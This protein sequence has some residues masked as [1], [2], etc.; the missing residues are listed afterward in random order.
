MSNP[1]FPVSNSMPQDISIEVDSRYQNNLIE[2]EPEKGETLDR[3][4]Y[5]SVPMHFSG[6]RMHLSTT[7]QRDTLDTFFKTT[8]RYGSIIFDWKHPMTQA[9]AECKMKNL[10]I[11]KLSDESYEATFDLEVLP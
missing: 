6:A 5:L 4:R 7:A 3:A 10:S 11:R 8:I 2:F 1:I 9:A